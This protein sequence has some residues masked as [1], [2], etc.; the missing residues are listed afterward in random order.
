MR[1]A[2]MKP[3]LCL[4][5]VVA[6]ALQMGLYV[7]SMV[8]ADEVDH[9]V[10]DEQHGDV[11]ET[12]LID[13]DASNNSDSQETISS[14]ETLIDA[15]DEDEPRLQSFPEDKLAS[16]SPSSVDLPADFTGDPNDLSEVLAYMLENN[17]EG[18]TKNSILDFFTLEF[19]DST[20]AVVDNPSIGNIFNMFFQFTLP[21][22]LTN[23]MTGGEFYEFLLPNELLVSSSQ[24]IPLTTVNGTQYGQIVVGTDGSIRI[25]FNDNIATM[26]GRVV[27]GGTLYGQLT[28]GNIAGPGDH[29]VIIPG[30]E[31]VPGIPIYIKPGIDA[32]VD[33]DGSFDRITNPN[34]ITWTVEFN[35]SMD[36]LTGVILT[37]S[38]PEG[39]IAPAVIFVEGFE[40]GFDGSPV[41]GSEYALQEGTDY[42]IAYDPADTEQRNPIITFSGTLNHPVRTIYETDIDRST[43]SDEGAS[44]DFTNEATLVGDG[45]INLTGEA[46]LTAVYF[47]RLEKSA[48][49]YDPDGQ[50]I[51]WE[52]RYNYNQTQIPPGFNLTDTIPDGMS[53]LPDTIEIF[54]ATFG[55][56]GEV[57]YSEQPINEEDFV[58]TD[59]LDGTFTLTSEVAFDAAIVIYYETQVD[60]I[61]DANTPFENLI[62]DEDGNEAAG[63]GTLNQQNVKK[64]HD[65][66]NVANN[67]VNWRISINGNNE[68]MHDLVVTDTFD[69]I[70]E[71]LESFSV[72]TGEG[73]VLEQG[74]DYNYA[75][76]Q[77]TGIFTL[78]FADT[79]NPTDETLAITYTAFY[80]Y[81]DEVIPEEI[82]NNA[83]VGWVDDDQGAHQSDDNDVIYTS[84]EEQQN[85]KKGGSYNASNKEIT[86]YLAVN[87]T[88]TGLLNAYVEDPIEEQQNFVSDSVRIYSYSETASGTIVRGDEITGEDLEAF[89]IIEPAD[90]GGSLY[91]GLPDGDGSALYYIEFRTSLDNELI[92]T[93][94]YENTAMFH[95]DYTQDMNLP[96]EVSVANGGTYV[97]KQGQQEEDGQVNWSITVNASQSTV[98]NVVVRDF[99]SSNQII[100]TSSVVIYPTRVSANGSIAVDHTQSPLTLGEDYTVT[101]FINTD[102]E[103]EMDVAFIGDYERINSPYIIEYD[104]T[105]VTNQPSGSSL[106]VSNNA[107]IIFDQVE[108]EAGSGSDSATVEVGGGSGWI[109]G[110][111]D[112]LDVTKASSVTDDP[113]AGVLFDVYYLGPSGD[114]DPILLYSS[115]ATNTDGRISLR[116]LPRGYYSFD[117][118]EPAVGYELLESNPVQIFVSG[119]TSE[120]IY[121]IPTQAQFTKTNADASAGL[122]NAEFMLEQLVDGAWLSLEFDGTNWV[123]ASELAT[124]AKSDAGGNLYVEGMVDTYGSGLWLLPSDS[125]YRLTEILAPEGY[126]LNPYS[127]YFDIDASGTLVYGGTETELGADE[128]RIRNTPGQMEMKKVDAVT[129]NPVA[130]A[131]FALYHWD[132]D[133]SDWIRINEEASYISGI[134][135]MLSLGDLQIGGRYQLIEIVAPNGYELNSDPIEFVVPDQTSDP[136]TGIVTNLLVLD[137]FANTPSDTGKQPR[138]GTFIPAHA[139]PKT[140][141]PFSILIGTL[142]ALLSLSIALLT[143]SRNRQ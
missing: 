122:A 12:S 104:V 38:L 99:P 90:N 11:D 47:G 37:D 46:S 137:D 143:R 132:D 134:D 88:N 10:L 58:F 25:E 16:I 43:V 80:D 39:L 124:A 107:S 22:E 30:E 51:S 77:N 102:G 95:N 65:S 123:P 20:G 81:R 64:S 109:I 33:K 67:S 116:E 70:P 59:N 118:L 62:R 69:P 4:V 138:S 54:T 63:S 23:M 44:L 121:N 139:M 136:A 82:Q 5:L 56:N 74:S 68:T 36:Q 108:E 15:E 126:A 50:T 29:E 141:D 93:D 87:Y 79:Y 111:L 128:Q 42:T 76:D 103:W 9:N 71:R 13:E 105:V 129:G 48:I 21:A 60:Y 96:A 31:D 57:I 98:T 40:V 131:E 78:T 61:L 100:D 73:D 101:Y 119:E 112:S 83:H 127:Y 113:L 86:W 84:Q 6:L 27:G 97:G 72:E 7:P 135:G 92:G 32:S 130:Q 19:F 18:I 106:E 14:S 53:I 52:V 140:A 8:L 142:I 110:E 120:T 125:E 55:T 24:S 2:F 91:V 75:F 17:Y 1:K 85:G 3:F 114:D 66:Y 89:T 41:V 26:S 45:D 117:E 115:V 34:S 35:K 28:E 94:T 133:E 49:D